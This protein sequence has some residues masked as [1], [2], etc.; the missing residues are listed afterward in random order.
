MIFQDNSCNS[1]NRDRPNDQPI[2]IDK[3]LDIKS[4]HILDIYEEMGQVPFLVACSALVNDEITKKCQNIG[5]NAII[6]SPM[7]VQKIESE[8]LKHLRN[9]RLQRQI[10]E[11]KIQRRQSQQK[12]I[13]ERVIQIQ[14]GSVLSGSNMQINSQNSG[15]LERVDELNNQ[16]DEESVSAESEKQ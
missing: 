12:S 10:L 15:A 14:E 1:F 3:S 6:E 13:Y 16:K 9:D 7:T 4:Q 2:E 5:F 8:I 11:D